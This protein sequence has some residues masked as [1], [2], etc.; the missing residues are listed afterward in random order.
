M[1]KVNITEIL[2]RALLNPYCMLELQRDGE[3]SDC[4]TRFRRAE[5]ERKL[6]RTE[7]ELNHKFYL[8]SQF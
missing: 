4:R 5:A 3:R 8:F 1:V 6:S 7:K 2:A